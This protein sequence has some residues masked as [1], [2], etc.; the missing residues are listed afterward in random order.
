MKRWL[1]FLILALAPCLAFA[2]TLHGRV[3]D[4]A[5]GDT[6][7][8]LLPDHRQ[9]RVRLA[10]IDAPESKQ[11]YGEASK[12]HLFSLV[13]NRQVVV[14]TNKRDSY[15]RLIGKVLVDG[16][17]ACLAQIEAGL[18]WHYKQFENEQSLEDRVAY[19]L[20]EEQALGARRGLWAEPDPV[21]PW[22]WRRGQR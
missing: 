8:L 15:G 9:E 17:D 20:A 3:V 14:V 13:Y 12:R 4:V 19:R 11:P 22:V 6:I 2:E 5:D 16:A 7:T 1:L 10:G 21:P 18:A